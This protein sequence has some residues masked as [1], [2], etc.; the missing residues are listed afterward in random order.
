MLPQQILT[1]LKDQPFRPFRIRMN[2]GRTYDIPHPEIAKV[3]RDCVMLFTVVS[4]NP[5]VVDHW[6]TISLLLVESIEHLDA[7]VA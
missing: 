4:D 6:E 5:E 1:H 2:S 7:Q 3:G